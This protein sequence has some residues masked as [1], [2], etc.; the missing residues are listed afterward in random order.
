MLQQTRVAA[1]IPY[2]EKFVARFPTVHD[3]AA[4]PLDEVLR[5]WAGLGYYSRA[6][7]LQRAAQ[8]IV[9][10]HNGEFPRDYASVL[11]LPGIGKYTAAAILSIAF[12]QPDAALDGNVA[13][14]LARMHAIRGNLR[15]PHR[16]KVLQDHADELLARNAPGDWNQAMMEIGATICTPRAALCSEC[17]LAK[18]CLARKLDLVHEIPG[19]RV[20]RAPLKIQIAAAVIIDSRGRTL[21]VKSA[22]QRTNA[23]SEGD[24]S[25]LFSH[26]WHFPAI[27][28]RRDGRAELTGYLRKFLGPGS[29]VVPLEKLRP[30]RHCV[31]YRQIT[32]SPFLLR[33]T[34]MPTLPNSTCPLLADLTGLSDGN[35]GRTISNATRKIA[36]SAWRAIQSA[37]KDKLTATK[38]APE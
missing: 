20:K 33:V 2:F 7:N 15:E 38:H 17:P 27:A 8:Q 25:T 24:I 18:Q 29:S 21:L 37:T 36:S 23:A 1:V 35:D 10:Q 6:R 34:N 13:R 14:V 11:A 19:K 9:A 4:A 30:A 22:A 31:T 12:N 26:M 5:S 28:A 32:L 3:L 16:W